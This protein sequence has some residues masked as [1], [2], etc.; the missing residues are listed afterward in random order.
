MG[1]SIYETFLTYG[2]H[3]DSSTIAMKF[4]GYDSFGRRVYTEDAL[5]GAVTT[6]YDAAGNVV[7]KT[8]AVTPVRYEYDTSGR[9]TSLSTTRNGI[10]WDMTSFTY[11]PRTGRCTAKYYA[12]GA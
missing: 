1:E 3:D 9:C 8:G 4:F 5:G 2:K 6:R 10:I 11:N 12:D 7:E